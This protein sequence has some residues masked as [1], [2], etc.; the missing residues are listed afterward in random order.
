MS[1]KEKVKSFYLNDGIRDV[2]QLEEILHDDIILH[3]ESSEGPIV[4]NKL[5]MLDYSKELNQ[6]FDVSFIEISELIE[7]NNKIVVQY[8]QK[9]SP[10]ESPN[11]II[12][13]VKVMVIWEMLEGKF[14][15]G[16]QFTQQA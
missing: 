14:I 4:F 8:V 9:V 15:K 12:P 5:Q 7:E 3:W 6:K 10:I 2:V 16:N 11:E 13:I 1:N